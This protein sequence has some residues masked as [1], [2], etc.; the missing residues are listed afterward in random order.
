MVTE[1]HAPET[2]GVLA[3]SASGALE[4]VP[5]IRVVNLARSLEALKAAGFW[6]LGLAEEGERELA[7][8][9]TS[10]VNG[11]IYCASVHARKAAFQTKRPEDVEHLLAVSLTRDE[12][13]LPIGVEKLAEGQDERWNAL[14]LLTAR[15]SQLVP[16]ATAAD[17]E[18][19][20]AVGLTREQI[21]DAVL[22]VAFFSWANRL[23]LSLGEP[24][25]PG[26][27]LQAG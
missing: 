14:I 12:N 19:L 2:T 20:A 24:A 3:K 8:A 26:T 15:L 5:L 6:C 10:K 16:R 27:G 23:M 18:R 22:A 25:I 13:W 9:V 21:G 11:C 17:V 7:A 4:V 1:R